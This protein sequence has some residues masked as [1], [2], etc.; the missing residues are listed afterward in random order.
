MTTV[1]TIKNEGPDELL[2]RFYGEDRKFKDERVRVDGWFPANL[3]NV[4]TGDMRR[5]VL[6]YWS[7][8]TVEGKY[9]AEELAYHIAAHAKHGDHFVVAKAWAEY[10]TAAI[11][12]AKESA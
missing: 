2:I 6:S 8:G 1:V 9:T 5:K 7:S 10:P 4:P 3:A 12:A 11:D